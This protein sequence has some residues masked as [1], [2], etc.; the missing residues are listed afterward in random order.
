M[1][2]SLEALDWLRDMVL[3]RVK[4]WPSLADIRGILCWKFGPADGIE[5]DSSVAGF[6][7]QDGERVSIE[8]GA[9]AVPQL[10]DGRVSECAQLRGMVEDLAARKML[11]AP[12]CDLLGRKRDGS[13]CE[14][15]VGQF[16]RELDA[17]QAAEV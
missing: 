16:A 2:P 9:L 15:R 6:T 17:R 5:A 12:C 1:I 11:P 3:A 14:C 13:F 10:I 8:R 7:P 4:V